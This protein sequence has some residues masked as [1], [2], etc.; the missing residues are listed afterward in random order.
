[1]RGF[2]ARVLIE[3]RPH[4]SLVRL[5]AVEFPSLRIA[6]R[7][8]AQTAELFGQALRISR[9]RQALQVFLNQ[10][11]YALAHGFGNAMRAT[12][13]FIIYLQSELG[14]PSI[15]LGSMSPC[16]LQSS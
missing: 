2:P 11:I 10:S 15:L 8:H 9:L 12:D 4:S 1:M 6:F 16:M 14:H 13:H 7:F 5:V 3:L